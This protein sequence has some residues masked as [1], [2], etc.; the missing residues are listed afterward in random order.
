MPYTFQVNIYKQPNNKWQIL[1]WFMFDEKQPITKIKDKLVH[2]VPL[3]PAWCSPAYVHH[4]KK[5]L[6]YLFDRL[7]G[8]AKL[9]LTWADEQ[10]HTMKK[11]PASDTQQHGYAFIRGNGPKASNL[12]Q[13]VEWMDEQ[14]HD[15]QSPYTDG[16]RV[17]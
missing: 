11:A 5:V 8:T 17:V 7:P 1:K 13:F 10:A 4:V 3:E 15:P 14:V 16:R 6:H 2:G 12:N 9:Y